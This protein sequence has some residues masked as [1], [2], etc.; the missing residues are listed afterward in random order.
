MKGHIRERSPG[1]WAIV[2]D[3][4]DPETGKRRRKWHKFHGTKRQAETECARLVAELD[5]GSYIEPAKTTVREYM[6]RWL[7]HEKAN[8]SPKTHQR[9][10]ELLLKNVAPVIGS[11]IMNKLTPARIDGCWTTLLESGRRPKKRR[12]ATSPTVEEKKG[13]SP[14]TV[15]HC[16]RVMLSAFEQAVKWDLLK[17][18]PVALTKPPK[19]EKKPMEAFNASQ[20]GVMLDELRKSRVFMAALLAALC[21]LRRGEI[22]ALRWRDVDFANGTVAIRESAEQVGTLVRYKETKSGKSR[23]VALSSTVLEEL[24]RHRLS[25]AEEQLKIGIRPDENSFIIAQIEGS[26][27]KPV[28]LTHEWTRL[29]AKTSLPRIRF[30]DLRH[31][32]ATQLLAAGVHPKIA[33]ERLGHSTIGIT[34]D[35]YSHVM[36]GM[37]ANAAEQVDAAIKAAKKPA[38]E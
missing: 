9:Y 7:A 3:V 22:V 36:P 20:T 18:N 19:V 14:R 34:L 25:Q 16:R 27:L 21:G 24:K 8:V 33:S 29:L 6:I 11:V 31:S 23:S 37:Q 15:H 32:H 5:G 4:P 1:K 12:A 35:L 26:P 28:S 30:H 13:L 10:E 17:K 2:L 38:V